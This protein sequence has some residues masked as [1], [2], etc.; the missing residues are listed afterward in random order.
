MDPDVR[1]FIERQRVARLASNDDRGAPHAVPIVFAWAGDA[2]Y[3]VIDEKPK[4]TRELRRLR[5]IE[6]DPRVTLL[7]DEYAEDWSRLGWVMLRALVEVVEDENE[8]SRALDAL[9]AKYPQY[10]SMVL[11][12]PLLRFT[13]ERETHWGRMG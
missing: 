12:G 9:R 1:A 11:D 10:A 5:N 13:P 8:R 3:S 7:F 4:R 2:C 6:A